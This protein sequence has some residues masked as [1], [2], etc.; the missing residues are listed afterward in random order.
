MARKKFFT[1]EKLR[2]IYNGCWR[3]LNV[4]RN[5]D[6]DG[7]YLKR[8]KLVEITGYKPSQ[9]STALKWGRRQFEKG[10]LSIMQWIMASPKGY[11]LPT[12]VNEDR[13]FA[14]AVQNIKD[15]RSRSKTQTPLYEALL[16]SY[17][18]QLRAALVK[19]S[20]DVN[21]VNMEMNPWAVFNE[22]M[23]NKYISPVS[24]REEDD[25]D[26]YEGYYDYE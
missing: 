26:Y 17:P 23:E 7:C 9:V 19:S 6:G 3:A 1:D 10:N 12:S 5:E 15:I 8:D 18:E 20:P 14:Y 2:D 11:F 16:I 22:I 24:D 25:E 4:I 21:D 13:V